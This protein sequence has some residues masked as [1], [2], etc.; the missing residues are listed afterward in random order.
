[1]LLL[2]V[3]RTIFSS[4]SILPFI[5]LSILKI[6]NSTIYKLF[7]LFCK[8]IYTLRDGLL[9][10]SQHVRRWRQCKDGMEWY[11]VDSLLAETT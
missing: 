10:T 7:T 1:V 9:L 4:V 5:S 2:F 6:I 3:I 8:S 11:V